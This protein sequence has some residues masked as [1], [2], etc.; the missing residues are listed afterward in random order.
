ML[1]IKSQQMTKNWY[2][3]DYDTIKLKI[4]KQKKDL[5]CFEI[6]KNISKQPMSKEEIMQ[7][8]QNII[9]ALNTESAKLQEV[10]W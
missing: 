6:L 7:F 8:S 5:I 9:Q 2:R 3:T 1:P 4:K 10:S